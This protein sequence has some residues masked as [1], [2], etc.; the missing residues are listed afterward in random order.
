MHH[1]AQQPF[2]FKALI[3][4]ID[5]V[6]ADSDPKS[7]PQSLLA[8]FPSTAVFK[9]PACGAPPISSP[10]LRSSYPGRQPAARQPARVP[11]LGGEIPERVVQEGH[12]LSDW[13][14]EE[15]CSDLA[16]SQETHHELV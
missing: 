15:D 3:F 4:Y 7:L 2:F 12:A 11:F 16:H 8:V 6:F 1:S 9:T 13:A 10:L 14:D 5:G